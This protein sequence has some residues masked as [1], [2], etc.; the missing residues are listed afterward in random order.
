MDEEYAQDV[1]YDPNMG[2]SDGMY[3]GEQQPAAYDPFA[4]Y[5]TVPMNVSFYSSI[6]ESRA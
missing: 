2:A 1:M 6:S 5:M 3:I 4:T